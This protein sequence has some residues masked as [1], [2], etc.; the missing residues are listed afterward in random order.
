MYLD[1]K[2]LQEEQKQ[3]KYSPELP[4]ISKR[5]TT[6]AVNFLKRGLKEGIGVK[7]S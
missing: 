1:T 4:S 6:N 3:K 7:C 2:C 5:E